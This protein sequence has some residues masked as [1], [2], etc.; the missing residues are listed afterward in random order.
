MQRKLQYYI[1]YKIT[2]FTLEILCMEA[3]F[4]SLVKYIT[5][6][7]LRTTIFINLNQPDLLSLSSLFEFK[8]IRIRRKLSR[9]RWSHALHSLFKKRHRVSPDLPGYFVDNI[10]QG[11]RFYFSYYHFQILWL[12]FCQ[13]YTLNFITYIIGSIKQIN[14]YNNIKLQ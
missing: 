6:L 13:I 4:F 12:F 7:Y 2:F 14:L 9:F 3:I 11:E 10:I 8:Q 1:Q 5:H